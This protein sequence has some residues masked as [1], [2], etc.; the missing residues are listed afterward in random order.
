MI[1]CHSRAHHTGVENYARDRAREL[2]LLDA[3]YLAMTVS[4][5]QVFYDWP[6]VERVILG[7]IARGAHRWPRKRTR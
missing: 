5:E 7:I 6:A 1:E 2:K 3:G 4:Y